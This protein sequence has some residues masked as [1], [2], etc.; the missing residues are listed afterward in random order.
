MDG[1]CIRKRLNSLK[2]LKGDVKRPTM[3]CDLE[4]YPLR[5]KRIKV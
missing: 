5:Q 2:D 1:Y 3:M 4:D